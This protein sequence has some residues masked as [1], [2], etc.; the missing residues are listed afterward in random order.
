MDQIDKL[1]VSEK[2][3]EEGGLY[4]YNTLVIFSEVLVD[5]HE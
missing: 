5:Y 1:S 3:W 2:M 4:T